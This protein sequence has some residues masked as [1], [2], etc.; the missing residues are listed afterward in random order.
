MAACSKHRRKDILPLHADLVTLLRRWLDGLAPDEAIFPR[1]GKRR[2]WLMVR[3][4]LERVDIPYR[5]DQ[6]R[7]ADFH[8][9][10]RHTHIT[11]L[12]RN[13]ASVAEAKELARH[14]DVRMTMKYAHI[15]IQDQ[16]KAIA[17]LPVSGSWLHYGCI[18]EH[19]NSHSMTSGDTTQSGQDDEDEDVNP[20]VARAMTRKSTG[21]PCVAQPVLSG[22]GGDRSAACFQ[23]TS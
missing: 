5:D 14:T 11:E 7:V 10:G 1:L 16:A 13:G 23:D 6:N 9:A 4:D 8:A 19:S 20:A 18:S 3:K 21:C 17:K 12:L 2:T 15:G 22:G